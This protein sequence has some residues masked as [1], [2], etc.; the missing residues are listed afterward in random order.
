MEPII[1]ASGSPRRQEILKMMGIPFQVIIPDVDESDTGDMELEL[2]PEFLASKKVEYVTKVLPPEQEVPWILGA[3]TL[4]ILDGKTY[5]KPAD[6]DEATRFLETFSGKT[7]TVVTSLAL[8]NGNLHF[9][10]TRTCKTLVTFTELSKEEIDW[11]LSTGE[12][13]NAAGGYRIQGLASY[14]IRKIEGTNSAVVGLPLFELY[15][16]L[17]EQGYSLIGD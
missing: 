10:S 15:D 14:F 6:T 4:T 3:D 16:M 5:G 17:K 7:Q 13:H 9:L 12:W 2:I 8:Y 1:L 11:Y